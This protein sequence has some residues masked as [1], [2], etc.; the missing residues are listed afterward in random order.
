LAEQEVMHGVVFMEDEKIIENPQKNT[1]VIIDLLKE[2]AEEFVIPKEVK[3]KRVYSEGDED[4]D[5]E[6]EED[7]DG[8][9]T[10]VD[11]ILLLDD[12]ID[13]TFG[14]KPDDYVFEEKKEVEKED[15]GWLF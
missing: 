6:M 3:K 10:R 13:D 8:N 4:E 7:E 15:D 5:D 2:K 1:E 12:E 9:L 11:E 14:E